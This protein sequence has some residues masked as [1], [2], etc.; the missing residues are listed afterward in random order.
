MEKKIKL[1]KPN[2]EKDEKIIQ[3]YNSE[4]NNAGVCDS[5]G[6]NCRC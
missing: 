5:V 4:T 3:L 1:E 2:V 6:N